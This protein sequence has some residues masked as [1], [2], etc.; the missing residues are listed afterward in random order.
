MSNKGY[1]PHRVIKGFVF[2]ILAVCIAVFTLAGIL[3]SWSAIG[4]LVASRCMWTAFMLA[5]GSVAFLVVNYLF[6]DFEQFF[7]GRADPPPGV[8]PAFAD[9]LKRAKAEGRADQ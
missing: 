4:E 3:R 6:G 1:L 5:L 2:W 9:R 8:D 7:P